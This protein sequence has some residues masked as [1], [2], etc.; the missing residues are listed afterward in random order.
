MKKILVLAAIMLALPAAA[1]AETQ[2]EK[3]PAVCAS[4]TSVFAVAVLETQSGPSVTTGPV[5]TAQLSVQNDD[6][7][8]LPPTALPNK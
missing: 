5:V 1:S 8:V 3:R 4:M 6:V 7:V 2:C